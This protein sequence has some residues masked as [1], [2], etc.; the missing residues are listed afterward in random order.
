MNN[1]A[2][3]TGASSGIGKAL[4]KI[5]AASG[6]LVIIARSEDKLNALKTI[7]NIRFLFD[8]LSNLLRF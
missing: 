2:L 4:A 6:D 7:I 8:K 3:I 1:V 5:H